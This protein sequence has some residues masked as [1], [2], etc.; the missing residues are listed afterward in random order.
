MGGESTVEERH[1]LEGVGKWK[2]DHQPNRDDYRDSL[3]II[4]DTRKEDRI[5]SRFWNLGKEKIVIDDHK[6]ERTKF[7]DY[8]WIDKSYSCASE[9]VGHLVM[10]SGL[11]VSEKVASTLLNGIISESNRFFNVKDSKDSKANALTLEIASFLLEK[12]ADLNQ[13]YE[14]KFLNLSLIRSISYLF[15]NHT[16]T[17]GGVAYVVTNKKIRKDFSNLKGGLQK[18]KE[19]MIEGVKVWLLLNDENRSGGITFSI[20]S[21]SSWK[22]ADEIGEKYDG[23]GHESAAGGKLDGWHQWDDFIKDLEESIKT[24]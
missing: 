2:N 9:M 3:V 20:R 10:Q 5:D 1:T 14:R 7:A 13:I 11:V 22:K 24:N 18:I 17:E 8:E 19:F 21:A 15:W 12:G 6:G 4:S 16:L 23:G